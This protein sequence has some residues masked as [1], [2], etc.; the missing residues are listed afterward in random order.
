MGE[1]REGRSHLLLAKLPL[2]PAW[3]LFQYQPN[4]FTQI[5]RKNY[6]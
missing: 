3:A 6:N 4:I 2:I 1:V 5:L